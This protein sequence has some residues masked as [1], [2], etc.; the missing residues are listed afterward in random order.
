MDLFD[1]AQESNMKGTPLADRIRSRDLTEF[2][3]QEHIVGEGKPLRVA[4]EKDNIS[5]IIFWGPPG[6]GKTTLARIIASATEAEFVAFSAVTSGVPELRKIIAEAKDLRKFQGKSTIL[7]VDEIHR[8]NK[9]QQDAFLPH[10][11]DGTI[12]LIGATTA[13]PSF[14]VIPPL[15][16]RVR[17]HVLKRLEGRHLQDILR[18]ALADTER[19][20]GS[21]DLGV[22]DE[23][24]ETIVSISDGDARVALNIL[25]ISAFLA[26]QDKGDGH[27]DAETA[28]QAAQKKMLLYDKSGEEHFNLIS[29]LHKSL[30]DSDPDGSLYWL[31]RMLEAGEDPLYIARRMVRCASEDVGLADPHALVVTMAAMQA[32]HFLGMPECNLALAEAA[33]YLA[34]APK[35]NSLETAYHGVARDVR[36]HGSLPVPLHIRNAPTSLMKELGYGR[37]YK[38]AHNYRHGQVDQQ[39]LPPELEGHRY[40]HPVARGYE[41]TI[42]ER[43]ERWRRI[44]KGKDSS[45]E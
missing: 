7:F 35:S 2:E 1:S 20:L 24:L 13:N 39:H 43:L 41:K 19:G 11:E 29:A 37:G 17:V 28:M 30:R 8:F 27:I 34:T 25:E 32:S 14:E 15:L 12:I 22:D 5:S 31:G 3:G 16:S 33:V 18:R 9:A 38:Y 42:A 26:T 44:Q 21:M 6:S 36:E 10:V 45:E 40:Y 4:I 23:A